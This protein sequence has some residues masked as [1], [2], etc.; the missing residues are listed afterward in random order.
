MNIFI[1]F[2][3]CV[4]GWQVNWRR[5]WERSM[6]RCHADVMTASR[7][8]CSS[9]ALPAMTGGQHV[10]G[11]ILW[12]ARVFFLSSF[13]K[14]S[15]QVLLSCCFVVG[16]GHVPKMCTLFCRVL[17]EE[18]SCQW[19]WHVLFWELLWH[20]MFENFF[21]VFCLRISVA[22]S[23]WEFLWLLL[24]QNICGVSCFILSVACSVSYFLWRVRIR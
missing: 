3:V 4:G 5:A 22:C 7:S 16:M 15:K 19:L 14:K 23:A 1:H 18:R 24:F 20:V 12:L 9:V 2:S 13:L 10:F 17:I 8:A 21:G 11:F 6:S